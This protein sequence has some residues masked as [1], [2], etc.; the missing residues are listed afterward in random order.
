MDEDGGWS[1]EYISLKTGNHEAIR[2]LV[3]VQR[4]AQGPRR[5]ELG[6]SVVSFYSRAS[7]FTQRQVGL[8]SSN[9]ILRSCLCLEVRE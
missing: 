3:S 4:Q 7:S 2:S 1:S 6:G 5:G 9:Q 8:G